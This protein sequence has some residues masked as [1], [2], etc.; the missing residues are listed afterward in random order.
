VVLDDLGD[1]GFYGLLGG[2]VGI[3]CGDLGDPEAWL[4]YSFESTMLAILVCSWVLSLERF[5]KLKGL[6][7]CLLLY[8]R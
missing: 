2:N 7:L 1:D 4:A 5:H 6:L 8:R 3:V